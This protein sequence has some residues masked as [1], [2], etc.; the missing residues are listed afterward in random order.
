MKVVAVCLKG[1]T[2]HKGNRYDKNS[3]YEIDTTNPAA[4]H[5]DLTGQARLDC[6]EAEKV[7]RR[8]TIDKQTEARKKKTTKAIASPDEFDEEINQLKASNE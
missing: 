4:I 5:F 1:C 6:L 2:D 3:E 7:R 8:E